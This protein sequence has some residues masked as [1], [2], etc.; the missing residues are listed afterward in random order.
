VLDYDARVS[1]AITSIT[2][3]AW[4][5]AGL[6]AGASLLHWAA[7]ENNTHQ[8]SA[9]GVLLI[10]AASA[11]VLLAMLLVLAPWR[12]AGAP[13]AGLERTVY[14]AGAALNTA[15][16]LALALPLVLTP[17]ADPHPSAHAMAQAEG[18]GP[19]TI[20]ALATEVVLVGLLLWMVR[21]AG[22][23]LRSRTTEEG[24]RAAPRRQ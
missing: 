2:A 9:A 23:H 4:L 3:M 22:R 21:L 10:A 15:V 19:L 14:V 24:L 11:Q 12:G 5:A 17:S 13:R 7:G 6:A 8:A 20:V 1:S 16:F 18:I